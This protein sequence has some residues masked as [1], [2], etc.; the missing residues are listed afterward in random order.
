MS[1]TINIKLNITP[2]SESDKK[3]SDFREELA[4]DSENSN[5]VIID[6]EIGELKAAVDIATIDEVKQYLNIE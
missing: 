4:G 5:M 3:F 6:R 2:A 1:K